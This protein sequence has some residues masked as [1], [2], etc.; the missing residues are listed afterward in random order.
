MWFLMPALRPEAPDSC[1]AR[2]HAGKAPEQM[3]HNPN[4][5]SV[6]KVGRVRGPAAQPA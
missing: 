5:H 6:L 3:E 1:P 2:E 4:P